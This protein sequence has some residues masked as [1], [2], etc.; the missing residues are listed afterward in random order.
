MSQQRHLA[1]I[2]FTD[3]VG[4]T[5]LMQQDEHKAVALIR[6]YSQSIERFVALH[7][8]KILNYYGDGSLCTFPSATEAVNCALELQKDLQTDPYVPLRIGLH[9][10]EVF[11][12]DGKAL[13]DGVNIASRIQSLGESN[14]ILLSKEVHDKIR[15]QPE[16]KTIS[17]GSFD[18]KNVDEPLEV[19]A[20][21]NEGLH[22]P[23]RE[24]M[25]GKLKP[26]IQA[27]VNTPG[28]IIKVLIAIIALIG[29]FTLIYFKFSKSTHDN[30]ENSVA[31]MPFLNMSND[32]NQGYFAEGMM[33]EILNHLY[34]IGGLK[35]SSRST[36]MTY[37][38]SKKTSKEISD[39]LGVANLLEGSVQRDG[40]SVRIIV[41]LINGK[42]DDHIWAETYDRKFKDV[43][44]IQSEIAQQVAAALKV[45]IDAGT[46]ERIEFVP[47]KNISAYTLYLK[48][49]EKF[50][51]D[52]MEEY[53]KR[54]QECIQLDP[55]FAPA[56][57]DLG[58][59]WLLQGTFAGKLN[60]KQ[61]RDSAY[62]ALRKAILLDSNLASAR[63]YFAQAKLWYDWDFKAANA[64]WTKFFLLNPSGA[65]WSDNYL[66]FLRASGRFQEALN[67]SF[68]NR[69]TDKNNYFNWQEIS[70]DFYFMN[71]PEKAMSV[72]DSATLH[73]G[74]SLQ[75]DDLWFLVLPQILTDKYQQALENLNKFFEASPDQ[76]KIPRWESLL[77]ICY[78]YT[79][80]QDK[81]AIIV[82]SLQY[83][84]SQSP[85]KSPAF[86][87]A[88]IYA[89][90]KR[91]APALQ[92]LKTAYNNH[93]VEMYWLNVDPMF[94]S[95]RQEPEFKKLI[96]LIGFNK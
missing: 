1:A 84:S 21:S 57:A 41:Q 86:Y 72:L 9:I 95:L 61:V 53:K 30:I 68:K 79:G 91:P 46:K 48:S 3:I 69:E 93:E 67:F 71:Q 78:Y 34:K 27:K 77:S 74:H 6:H 55:N 24:Q 89:A 7:E 14:T 82:D 70:L 54:L 22:V 63:N 26:K 58:F 47:T 51:I 17:L 94:N 85:V 66:D 5:A 92:W 2:L 52:D 60:A 8:G 39:E 4:Y 88:S 20:L 76:A 96:S 36:S 38:G 35:V 13:G 90:T 56:Y 25:S 40:D 75:A 87:A 80:H 10:G 18:F 50:D 31:V 32:V 29:I 12:E 65:T 73:F 33:D 23:V 37:A 43:F 81:S 62:P 42:T 49:K 28:K 11:F 83:W 19:F 45:K 15:N 64:E 59:Y 44:S 16:F